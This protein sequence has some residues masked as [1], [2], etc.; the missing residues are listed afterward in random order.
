MFICNLHHHLYYIVRKKTFQH[1]PGWREMMEEDLRLKAFSVLSKGV[2]CLPFM[3]TSLIWHLGITQ[4]EPTVYIKSP[5]IPQFT[6]RYLVFFPGLPSNMILNIRNQATWT[7]HVL[8]AGYEVNFQI[9]D[10][11]WPTINNLFIKEYIGSTWSRLWSA[12][13]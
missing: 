6:Q 8:Q 12:L 3:I 4:E 9:F 11:Q 1:H 7:Q 5:T 2:V 13:H 10:Y